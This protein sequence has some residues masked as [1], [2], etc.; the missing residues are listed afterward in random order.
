MLAGRRAEALLSGARACAPLCRDY[1]LIDYKMVLL[2]ERVYHYSKEFLRGKGFPVSGLR[3][4]HELV[5]RGLIVDTLH[6][7]AAMPYVCSPCACLR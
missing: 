3:F 6:G 5:V 2:E 1:T 7:H 4:T